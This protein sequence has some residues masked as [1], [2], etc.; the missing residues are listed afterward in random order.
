MTFEQHIIP[1]KKLST[2]TILGHF[3][4]GYF[5]AAGNKQEAL[6][7]QGKD[8]DSRALKY[9]ARGT[10]CDRLTASSIT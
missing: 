7:P 5:P 10:M 6:L 3:V 2:T 9:F 8:P 1:K 4:S